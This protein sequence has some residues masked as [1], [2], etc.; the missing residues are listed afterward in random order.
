MGAPAYPGTLEEL[1]ALGLCVP[2]PFPAS[3]QSAALSSKR[4]V[5]GGWTF[6][7]TTGAAPADMQL[8]DGSSNTG[9][10]IAEITLSPG[11]SIRDVTGYLAVVCLRGIWVQ[12]NSGTVRGSVWAMLAGREP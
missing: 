5:I 2:L 6:R 3:N 9:V 4:E 7:E 1:Q 10:I 11:Q 8:I 12:V